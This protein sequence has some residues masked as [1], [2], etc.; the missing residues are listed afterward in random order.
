MITL[1]ASPRLDHLFSALAHQKR[2]GILDALS[3]R[4]S[5]VKQLADEF[6]LSLP[7]MHKHMDTLE[8]SRLV[9]R[10]KVG[11]TNFVALNKKT[12][13]EVQD[14]I[15][16]YRT[17]WGNDEETLENYIASFQD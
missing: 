1:Y 4:P 2:R 3:Y 11:R 15:M 17:D 14:W 5:T 6:D 9:R 13:R 7:A 12:L 10:R 8:K 16:Q